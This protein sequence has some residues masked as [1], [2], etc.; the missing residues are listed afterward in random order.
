MNKI[1]K[2]LSAAALIT[3]A[4]TPMLVS[5]YQKDNTVETLNESSYDLGQFEISSVEQVTIEGQNLVNGSMEGGVFNV[6]MNSFDIADY[7]GT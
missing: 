2:A 4:S 3:L 7:G 6:K 1:N 5:S